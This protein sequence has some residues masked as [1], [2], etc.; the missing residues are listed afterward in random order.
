M[1]KIYQAAWRQQQKLPPADNR[2]HIINLRDSW[3]YFR[4]R[5]PF[6]CLSGCVIAFAAMQVLTWLTF[7][8][9]P[10]PPQQVSVS[11]MHYIYPKRELPEKRPEPTA[12]VSDENLP[13][14]PTASVEN[15]EGMPDLRAR[16][17]QA[18]REQKNLY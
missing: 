9:S 14:E 15:I 13:S 8:E 17:E 2:V 7:K 6:A 4:L 10:L 1:S 18:M 5:A 16:L 12:F 11:T 3:R